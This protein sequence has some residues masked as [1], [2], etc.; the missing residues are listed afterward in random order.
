MQLQKYKRSGEITSHQLQAIGRPAA[1]WSHLYMSPRHYIHMQHI[2]FLLTH[3]EVR[4]IVDRIILYER[5]EKM[6]KKKSS[7]SDESKKSGKK[8][9]LRPTKMFF[10]VEVQRKWHEKPFFFIAFLLARGYQRDSL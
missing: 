9:A 5:Q 6:K 1:A 2:Y 3:I 10:L 7:Y 8:M 4:G